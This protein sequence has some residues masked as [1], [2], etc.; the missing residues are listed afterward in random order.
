M[1]LEET[2]I[3]QLWMKGCE[4]IARKE[5]NDDNIWLITKRE[6]KYRLLQC[7]MLSGDWYIA[8][9]KYTTDL[10]LCKTLMR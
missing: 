6:R 10:S 3:Y 2:R 1:I 8:S 9:K 4:V 5:R 7:I